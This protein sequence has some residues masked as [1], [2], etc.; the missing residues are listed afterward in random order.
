MSSIVTKVKEITEEQ[1]REYLL[2]YLQQNNTPSV[3]IDVGTIN[4]ILEEI[5][6][7]ADI[8]KIVKVSNSSIIVQPRPK[9]RIPEFGKERKINKKVDTISKRIHELIQEEEKI[10]SIDSTATTIDI[11]APSAEDTI[12]KKPLT[13]PSVPREEQLQPLIFGKDKQVGSDNKQ[14]NDNLDSDLDSIVLNYRTRID[15][16]ISEENKEDWDD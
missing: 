13:M 4:I 2:L 6:S 9:F 3:T 11:S 12:V 8:S 14:G 15:R 7:I 16:I 1:I 10:D 5:Y